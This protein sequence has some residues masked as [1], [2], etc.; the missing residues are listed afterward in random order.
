MKTRH[1]YLHILA[2]FI[3]LLATTAY[4]KQSQAANYRVLQYSLDRSAAPD[5]YYNKITLI[6]QVGQISSA[7][8][9]ADGWIVPSRYDAASGKLIVTTNSET[10][11]V[12]I[13]DAAQFPELG[14]FEIATLY[15]DKSWAWS[16]GFDDNTSF[17]ESSDAY[18]ALGYQASVFM[19]GEAISD[20]RVEYWILDASS[21]I[22]QRFWEPPNYVTGLKELAELEW[23]IGNHGWGAYSSC[24]T[25]ADLEWEILNNNQRLLE[26]ISLSN[27]PSYK[28]ISMAAPCFLSDYQ[29]ILL[30]LRDNGVSRAEFTDIPFYLQFNES[31][32]IQAPY[33]VDSANDYA[34]GGVT[35]RA[36][37]FD[38]PISRDYRIEDDAAIVTEMFDWMSNNASQNRHFW[39]NTLA[40]GG[41][42]DTVI[43]A[44]QYA[45]DHYGRAG[46][47]EAWIAPSERI[48]SYLINRDR[49][50]V[51][52]LGNEESPPPPEMSNFLYLPVVIKS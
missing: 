43:A 46:S 27:N 21:G 51:T 16:Q 36:F 38:D 32:N 24:N 9:V 47:D 11:D 13:A 35:A 33:I 49:I 19:I 20:T 22:D 44:L 3:C 12:Y 26:I 2:A 15:D 52:F 40:H 37:D 4:F 50:M 31:G 42:N 17:M 48:Y 39:Y 25:A 8:A 23:G 45:H 5:L 7:T 18:K 1:I 30:D 34:A 10:L 41:N 6:I 28:P 29:D 14:S